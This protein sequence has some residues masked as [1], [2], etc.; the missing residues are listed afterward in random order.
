MII[1][2]DASVD[3][4]GSEK[5]TQQLFSM[6]PESLTEDH[7]HLILSLHEGD[8]SK[9]RQIIHK[10]TGGLSY[11]PCPEYSS[12]LEEIQEQLHQ[13]TMPQNFMKL[14]KAFHRVLSAL[15]HME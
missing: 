10:I 6:L 14:N 12:A 3:K 1:D 2:W 8:M 13:D 4:T 15:E 11:C 5:L 7:E 9:A